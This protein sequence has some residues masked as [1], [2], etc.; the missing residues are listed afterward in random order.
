[1]QFILDNCLN[2]YDEPL[3]EFSELDHSLFEHVV[4]SIERDDEGRL[5]APALWDSNVE[6]RLAKNFNLAHKI[7]K[8]TVH[9]LRNNLDALQQY[10]SVIKEQLKEGIIC[11]VDDVQSFLKEHPDVSFLPHSGVLRENSETTKLRVVFLS[12]LSTWEVLGFLDEKPSSVVPLV[13][14][15]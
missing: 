11:Q 5:V 2:I 13:F 6:H 14:G 3:L 9:K 4:N 7:L 15:L 12:N 10:D 8:S 1:M